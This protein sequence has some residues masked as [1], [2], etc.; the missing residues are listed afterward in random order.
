MIAI[1]QPIIPHYRE[2]FF[3]QL[4]QKMDCDVYVYDRKENRKNKNLK[5]SSVHTL[6]VKKI[7]VFGIL[8]YSVRHLW[9][10]KYSTLVLMANIGHVSTWFLLF[11]KRFHGK[12]IILW[13]HGIS[14]KRYM[15]EEQKPSRFM[16]FMLKNAD[17]LWF[18]T[19]KEAALWRSYFPQKKMVSL[20]NTISDLDKIKLIDTQNE[21]EK[22]K[23]E[24]GVKQPIVFIYCAR[25]ENKYRRPDLLE[26]VIRTL[27]AD[28]FGFIIIGAGQ[29]KPDLSGYSNVY[30][31][32][33]VYDQDLKNK[34]FGMADAYFQPAWC[35]LSI[36]EAMAYG[37]AVLTFKR[38]KTIKQCVEYHY[39]QHE[40]NGLIFNNYS[41]SI[42][43][44]NNISTNLLYQLGLNGREQLINQLTVENMVA[45]ACSTLVESIHT[46]AYIAILQPL[47]PHY[48]EAFFENLYSKENFDIF[49]YDQ[50]TSKHNFNISSINTTEI[51]RL[52]INRLLIYSIRPLLQKKYSTLVLMSNI[53]HI[54]TWFLL[55]TKYIHRKKV[56]LWGHGVSVKRYLKEENKPGFLLKMMISLSDTAWV[57]TE[58]EQKQWLRIFPHKKI[59]SLNN[60]ISDVERILN[61]NSP[62]SKEQLKKMYSINQDICFIFCARF[63]SKLRRIDLLE[64]V[65]NHVDSTKYGF[66]IIG[67][68]HIKPDFS[69]YNHVYDFGSNYDAD[70]KDDLFTI[71]DIYFQPAW[72]GLSVVE[73]LAYGKPVF[74]MKRNKQ[75]LQGVEYSYLIDSYNSK[76]FE[77]TDSLINFVEKLSELGI[78][79][80]S[81][82][83]KQYVIDNLM[84]ENMVSKAEF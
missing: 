10:K 20:N 48:R 66:I 27:N 47:I 65:I 26:E 32:G 35:G 72:V 81:A 61:Y 16:R 42:S 51:K 33:S 59:I 57:Y 52:N 45:K 12:K 23:K 64:Q 56:I 17:A 44:L 5:L 73:A 82:N 74:T 39:I 9:Q 69:K 19:E 75:I 29:Y 1:L 25:F 49:V 14:V 8:I 80:L 60:T 2:D 54:S 70:L 7:L 34:L 28:K 50:K 15:D 3:N 43:K 79:K 58:K 38:S 63:N 67:G 83:A 13:G 4:S 37:K 21:K 36:V 11:T 53:G 41:D 22:L 76:I 30:D 78:K 71:A 46:C 62:K 24:F 84:M 18:Y 77:D 31:F 68:G 55:F 6:S 40:K